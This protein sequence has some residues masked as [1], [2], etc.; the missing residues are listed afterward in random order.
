MPG[1]GLR[2]QLWWFAGIATA[3]VVALVAVAVTLA[4]VV[5]VV[6]VLAARDPQ[7]GT[8]PSTSS[9][10]V[11]DGAVPQRYRA[12]FDYALT[13][14]PALPAPVLAAQITQE[15]GWDPR[16][17]SSA[18][19][20]GLGQFMPG[21]WK[22]H[23]VDA[24]GGG[25]EITDPADSLASAAAYDCHLIDQVSGKGYDGDAV[26]LMLA[27][28]NAGPGAVARYEGVP[29]P[30]FSAGQTHD[31][32][33]AITAM[34]ARDTVE[35]VPGLVVAG[36]VPERPLPAWPVGADGLAPNAEFGRRWL[37]ASFGVVVPVSSCVASAGH[38]ED[39]YH[40]DGHACDVMVSTAGSVPDAA[41][42]QL[43][44]AVANALVADHR[45][46]GVEQV[47]WQGRIWTAQRPTW[48][49]YENPLGSSVTLD[50]LDHVHVSFDRG[51]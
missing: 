19:A 34:A 7:R 44:W 32:V 3:L 43:G 49:D 10:A 12:A 51:R 6:G 36:S 20:R 35:T 13:L 5:V 24:N 8:A 23:A 39:S 18:G 1:V 17:V 47:I 16:A 37:Q 22:E 27:A 40:Y 25:A 11:A 28:Y 15:S 9:V 45:G 2:R 42:T 33:A 48:R 4:G 14:C 46:L 31:Y 38:V 21:T 50:H 29:P 26:S 30:S 41:G